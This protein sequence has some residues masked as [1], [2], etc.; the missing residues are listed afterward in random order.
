MYKNVYA[1]WVS[2]TRVVY[3]VG[4]ERVGSQPGLTACGRITGGGK[5]I[6]KKF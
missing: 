1:E 5:A 2:P 4:D 6:I 3:R